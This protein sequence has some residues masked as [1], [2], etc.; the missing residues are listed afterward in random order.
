MRMR[1]LLILLL[2]AAPARAEDLA[3][4]L[5][6]AESSALAVS[7][8]YRAARLSA[9]SAA[10]AA[11]TGALLDPRVTLEGSLRYAQVIPEMALPPL[12][13]GPRP[14]GDNWDYS[15]GPSLYW[16]VFDGGV[17]RS[18]REAALKTAAASRAE[19]EDI[20][21]QVLLKTR[22]A[23]FRLQLALERV[24]LIGENLQ[25]SLAQLSDISNG[26]KAG[27]RSRLDE[28]RARE[29]TLDRRR[30]LVQARGDLASA[31]RDLALFTG[32]DL[33][34]GASL[35]M[36]SRLEGL[37]LEDGRDAGLYIKAEPYGQ[38][39]QRFLP[40]AFAPLQKDLPSVAALDYSAGAYKAMAGSYRAERLP[41]LQLG[42]RSSI[43]YPNGPNIYSFLQN[44][45]S[46]S[47]SLPL[48]EGGSSAEKARGSELAAGAASE[49]KTWE[50][51]V[52][53]NRFRKALDAHA[54][55]LAEQAI[56][57]SAADDAQEA[58]RLAYDSYKSGGSTWLDVESADLKELQA[59]TASAATDAEI[60][61]NLALLDSLTG[62]VN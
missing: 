27:T 26:A 38:I 35:P 22:T 50:Q 43:D 40:A 62:S 34:S 14:L 13:G 5:S 3:L 31:L 56:N 51:L 46:L 4:T 36:D 6:T 53:E 60:L 18:G 39:L 10:A 15:V 16:T 19:E 9:E 23:Y 37:G 28:I 49:R 47:V 11:A 42:A 21:R 55:L 25:L 7:N 29:E 24:Y 45:A 2:A 12:L 58:A 57:K 44:S 32:L 1:I 48:F 30:D 33:P 59:K 20:R 61:L 17:L 8:E 52:S 41:R 54:E